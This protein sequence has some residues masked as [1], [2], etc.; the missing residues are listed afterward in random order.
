MSSMLVTFRNLVETAMQC[1]GAVRISDADG[2]G[3]QLFIQVDAQHSKYSREARAYIG[4]KIVPVE[5]GG[6][7]IVRAVDIAPA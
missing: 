2:S 6:Y 4:D 3:G 5:N 7:A 1:D